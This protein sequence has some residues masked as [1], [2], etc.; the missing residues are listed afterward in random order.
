[1]GR[2]EQSADAVEDLREAEGPREP[3]GR[4]WQAVRRAL[5]RLAGHVAVRDL[6]ESER[7]PPVAVRA[8]DLAPPRPI[9]PGG[10]ERDWRPVSE[11]HQAPVPQAVAGTYGGDGTPAVRLAGGNAALAPPLCRVMPVVQ[12]AQSRTESADL[13]L[14]AFVVRLPDA[15]LTLPRDP[16]RVLRADLVISQAAA[17]PNGRTLKDWGIKPPKCG[18]LRLPRI[19]DPR[20]RWGGDAVLSRIALTRRGLEPPPGVPFA[21]AFALEERRVAESAQLPPEDVLLLGVYP[22]VPILAVSRLVVAD[23]GRSLRLWLK[24]DVL[25][26]RSGVRLITLLVGRQT[27]TGKMLQVAL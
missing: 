9:A 10:R 20:V 19:P 6:S 17:A 18:A 1:M 4:A 12:A 27:S 15:F 24:P 2:R 13:L 8:S 26:G 22:G 23:E 3:A 5:G 25:R 21:Q 14:P 7:T 16:V 11:V